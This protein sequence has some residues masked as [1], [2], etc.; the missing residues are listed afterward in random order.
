LTLHLMT[1]EGLIYSLCPLIPDEIYIGDDSFRQIIEV[2][3]SEI[4]SSEDLT[5][6]PEK[7]H[8]LRSLKDDIIYGL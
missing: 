1:E 8:L 6:T 3:D 7:E 2:I 5:L 4:V